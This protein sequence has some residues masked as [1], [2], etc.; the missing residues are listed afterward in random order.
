M[1]SLP[2][3]PAVRALPDRFER[4]S[5]ASFMVWLMV[6]G[7]FAWSVNKTVVEPEPIHT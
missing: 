5:P 4:S 1:N 3:T 7:F 2:Q 6:L